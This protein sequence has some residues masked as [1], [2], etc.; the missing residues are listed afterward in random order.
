MNTDIEITTED[1]ALVYTYKN[2]NISRETWE[3]APFPIY[4]DQ[5]DDEDMGCIVRTLYDILVDEYGKEAVDDYASNKS[6][7][8]EE[9]ERID[10][11]RWREEESLFIEWGG[12]YYD[13]IYCPDC[14]SDEWVAVGKGNAK[15]KICGKVYK[16]ENK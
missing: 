11:L 4:C 13:D 15:C 9:W 2:I 6:I 1:G 16:M 10:D 7:N 8:T 3:S 5:L 12:V 14:E